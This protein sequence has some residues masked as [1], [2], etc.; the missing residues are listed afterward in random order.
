METASEVRCIAV[1]LPASEANDSYLSLKRSL[2]IVLASA[3]LVVVSPLLLLCCLAI[4]AESP[5]AAFF[6][7]V[8]VGARGRRFRMFKIRTMFS[9]LDKLSCVTETDDPRVTSFGRFLRLSKLDELP[10][11]F[12]IINGDMS[13]IG[14]RPLSEDECNYLVDNEG[15]SPEYPGFIPV[16]RPGLIGLEQVN[17]D[18]KRCYSERFD[19]NAEYERSISWVMDFDILMRAVNQCRAVVYSAVIAFSGEYIVFTLMNLN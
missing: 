7:Q 10:Q 3:L 11:L 4:A 12:N 1:T 2:D 14:P 16:S 13:I 17:R 5:G 15:M 18:R 19:L 9:G 8:R 6:T